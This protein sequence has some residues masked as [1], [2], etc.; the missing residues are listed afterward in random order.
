VRAVLLHRSEEEGAG[1][2]SLL[3]AAGWEGRLWTLVTPAVIREWAADPPDAILID[4]SLRPSHGKEVAMACRQRK[5]LRTTPLVFLEGAPENVEVLRGL[6]ADA[7]F[8]DWKRLRSALKL[9]LARKGK[10]PDRAP[11][12]RAPETPLAKKLGLVAGVRG[13][14]LGA[15]A[16]FEAALGA[17]PEGASLER[18]A[19]GPAGV[20]IQ[21]ARV[22]AELMNGFDEAVRALAARGK[23]WVAYP[24]QTSGLASD[25]TQAFVR[26]YALTRGWVDYKVCAIDIRWTGFC[27]SKKKG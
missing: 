2:L 1:R 9:A 22:R 26:E 6:H 27:F 24:K 3:R 15:P 5:G 21:F 11:A 12:H 13:V 19:E 17:L 23:L 7:V 20:V 10:I 25:L 14:A 18:D 16:E 8:G 4:L